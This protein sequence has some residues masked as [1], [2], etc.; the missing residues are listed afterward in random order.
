MENSVDKPQQADDENKLIAERRAK[1]AALR[2]QGPAFPSDFRRPAPAGRRAARA[3]T[4]PKRRRQ[5]HRDAPRRRR[6][7]AQVQFS[8]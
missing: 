4:V 8:D 5:S 1:L 2:E 7:V 3:L 6:V